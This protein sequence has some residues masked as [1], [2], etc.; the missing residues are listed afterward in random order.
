MDWIRLMIVIMVLN[1]TIFCG[2]FS[3]SPLFLWINSIIFYYI[4]K[5]LEI[6]IRIQNLCKKEN[7][8]LKLFNWPVMQLSHMQIH[9]KKNYFIPI[10]SKFAIFEYYFMFPKYSVCSSSSL[11][12]WNFIIASG[13]SQIANRESRIAIASCTNTL[14]SKAQPTNAKQM[15]NK[16]KQT[17]AVHWIASRKRVRWDQFGVCLLMQWTLLLLLLLFVYGSDCE[18]VRVREGLKGMR[19]PVAR[20]AGQSCTSTLSNQQTSSF[21]NQIY[22]SNR[23]ASHRISTQLNSTHLIWFDLLWLVW[24]SLLGSA[25]YQLLAIMLAKVPILSCVCLCLCSAQATKLSCLILM[26][27]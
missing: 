4:A 22:Y 14:G 26:F 24:L 9:T 12:H 11:K 3:L 18:E 6:V 23:I 5:T 27:G 20:A 25:T 10:Q 15:Q 17:R 2:F 21:V 7:I 1:L 13:F 16:T 19:W 8:Q